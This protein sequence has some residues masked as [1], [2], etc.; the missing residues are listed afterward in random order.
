MQDAAIRGFLLTLILSLGWKQGHLATGLCYF[1]AASMCSGSLDIALA[2][3]PAYML[4]TCIHSLIAGSTVS[5]DGLLL[6]VVLVP[7][8]GGLAGGF[9]VKLVA[10]L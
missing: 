7:L 2:I 1:V 8:L 3:N 6:V 5:V 9:L 4:G 10:S